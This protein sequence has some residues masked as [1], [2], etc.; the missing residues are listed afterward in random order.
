MLTSASSFP[1]LELGFDHF[2]QRLYIAV[3][4]RNN[5]IGQFDILD[6]HIQGIFKLYFKCYIV[7][8]VS[9]GLTYRAFYLY[10]QLRT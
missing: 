4:K 7:P 9:T 8:T 6:N 1:E 3:H 10:L 2:L 5:S